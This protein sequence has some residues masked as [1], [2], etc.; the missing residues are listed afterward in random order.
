MA[1]KCDRE[2][3]LNAARI[4]LTRCDGAFTK[5]EEG[6][7]KFDAVTVRQILN[8]DIFGISEL[9]DDEVEYLREKL[10]RY[11]QQLG[12]LGVD[13][14]RLERPITNGSIIIR[15]T[16]DDGRSGRISAKWMNENLP[17]KGAR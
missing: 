10:L 7:D 11:K 13:C 9:A 16:T 1:E 12:E 17:D 14:G 15:G 3:I 8:P 5:D 2:Y 4:L 6:Y